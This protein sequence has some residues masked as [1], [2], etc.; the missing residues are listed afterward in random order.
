MRRTTALGCTA[1]LTALAA[2]GGGDNL[3]LPGSG[4]P[5]HVTVVQGDQQN[6][7]VGQPLSQPLIVAVTDASDRLVDGATIVFVL[8]DPAPGASV[9][10]D[11]TTTNA[12]GQ[13]TAN[14][15]LGTRP[16]SQ[17]GE[18]Q[19]LGAGGAPTATVGFT[20]T[21]LPENANGIVALSGQD[22]SGPVNSTLPSPL[23]V[24]VSDPFGNPIGGVTVTWTV[25]G[26]GAVSAGTSTTGADGTTSV[27]RTLGATAGAQ[28]TFAA[29]DGLA[30]SPVTFTHTATAGAASGVTIVAGDDQTGPVLTELPQDLVVEVRDA[31]GNAVPSVAVT[32]VIGVG[33]GSV[34]PTTSVTD[35]SGRATAAWTLGASP[36]G[37]TVSA[38]VSGI[39]VAEFSATA[40]AGAPA[41]LHIQIQPSAAAV[42]GVPFSQQPV[43]QLLDAQGNEARQGGIAVQ[44]AIA[45][46]GGTLSGVTS[47]QTDANGSAVFSGL[48]L[49]GSVGTRTLRFSATG[50]ASVTS[51]QVSL[52]AAP[53]TTTITA[54][55][56]NPSNAGDPVT[57]QFT[58][59]SAA[60][61][62]TGTV[63]VQDGGDTCS[64]PLSGGAGSCTIR[65]NTVGSRT[66]TATY[67]GADGFAPSS[68]TAPHTVAPA[69]QPV[70][71]IATQPASTATLGV[72]LNPQPVIQL[73]DAGGGNL[74]TPGVQ[75]TAAIV[76][77]GGT[78]SGTTTVSTDA[79]G[80]A[81]FTDLAIN[82]DPGGRTL[83]FTAP[84]YGS[85][86]SATIDVQAAPPAPPSGAQSSVTVDPAAVPAG[87][88]STITVTVRDATGTPLVGRSV[89]VAAT[90]SDNTI[91]GNPGTTGIDGVATFTFS[92]PTA[93]AKTI[94]ATSDGVAL[95]T[96][97]TLT[98]EAAPPPT[99]GIRAAAG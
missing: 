68:A 58:V 22:Q 54:D 31:G 38:V 91:T 16:G 53:T 41:R 70:L 85:V 42:S 88:T 44:V 27:T 9:A 67:A 32:W 47:V 57:V 36:G 69:P 65:L 75:V 73:Q 89:T 90:G 97:Q 72:A 52:G 24:Q 61:T 1:L 35:A 51:Q 29:V 92:S 33:G 5:A 86:T 59:S 26:G 8:S 99:S 62:P 43:I 4:E 25:D 74:P 39:G 21:A 84:G 14:V 34:T 6:G 80:R 30:G 45:S 60:G 81:T 64:G 98:V 66:L 63:T 40:T 77:G 17:T 18:V 28:H 49:T 46:G 94:T 96:P 48:A 7:R 79:Q 11:T 23:V 50:Y 76:T 71:T 82:G 37:N 15:V 10:P 55:T 56:P 2:C 20:L 93:E 13:A 87:S 95:G 3:L 83:V 12:D 19:A 78:L